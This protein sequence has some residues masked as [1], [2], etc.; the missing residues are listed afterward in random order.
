MA[1]VA[2]WPPTAGRRPTNAAG[3]ELLAIVLNCAGAKC[4]LCIVWGCDKFWR[5]G[6][7]I[8]AVVSE[9]LIL[10]GRSKG[11]L[12]INWAGQWGP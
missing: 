9:A 7:D 1:S 12:L 10:I 2:S 3:G 5:G 11:G 8:P 6:W 4:G